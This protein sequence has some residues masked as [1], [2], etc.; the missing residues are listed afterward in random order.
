MEPIYSY[1]EAA[2]QLQF[3]K[4]ENEEEG[5]KE[6]YWF[7]YPWKGEDAKRLT[8]TDVAVE[9]V[10]FLGDIDS[11]QNIYVSPETAEKLK[12]QFGIDYFVDAK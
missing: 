5:V 8:G 10:G 2:D 6:I 4:K 1:E 12:K 9:L 3:F 7:M 11:F